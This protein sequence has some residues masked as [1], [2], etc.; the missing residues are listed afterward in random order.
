MLTNLAA[1]SATLLVLQNVVLANDLWKTRWMGKDGDAEFWGCTTGVQKTFKFNYLSPMEL[2]MMASSS[3]GSMGSMGSMGSSSTTYDSVCGYPPAIGSTLL[4]AQKLYNGSSKR[5]NTFFKSYEYHCKHES[6]VAYSASYYESQYANATEYQI[7]TDKIANISAPLYL[8]SLPNMTIPIL[9]SKAYNSRFTTIDNSNYFAIAIVL[10]F[11]LV[12]L[13][14]AVH[15]LAIR[16]GSIQKYS[17]PF[18]NRFRSYVIIPALFPHGKYMQAAGWEWCSTLL[19]NRVESIVALGLFV[20]QMV[21]WCVPYHG[22]QS[23]LPGGGSDG[24]GYLYASATKSWCRLVGYRTGIM[25]FGKIPLAIFFS[26]RNNFLTWLTGIKYSSLIQFHKMLSRYMFVD[27]LIHSIAFSIIH[28]AIFAS[29]LKTASFA[30]GFVATVLA[31]TMIIFSWHPFRKHTYEI[32]LYTHIVLAVGFLVTCWYHCKDDG[33]SEWIVAA[34]AYWAYDR[35]LRLYRM[36]TFGYKDAEISLV[37]G[38]TLKVVVKR[39]KVFVF[40]PGQYGFVYFSDS[41]LWFQSHPFSLTNHNGDI[42]MYIK[43][44]HGITD[45]IY[46]QL[47]ETKDGILR[48][49]VCIEGPYGKS[50][51][52][53]KYDNVVMF[54][55]GNGFPAIFGYAAKISGSSKTKNAKIIWIHRTL[56]DITLISREL[57][58]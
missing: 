24:G 42:L 34:C 13:I 16:T 7:P 29:M 23:S 2:E 33:W 6:T 14:A 10:Y 44:K 5:M 4:C 43:V 17:S 37:N 41:W 30:Y 11:A 15:N 36:A 8:P 9:K 40:K 19:P 58:S 53:F 57:I 35:L 51:P 21:F 12:L 20:L 50:A 45:K 31:A 22:A 52:V 3:S 18:I 54:T 56:E 38:D 25:S 28:K 1:V 39:P 49:K 47:L 48:K 27:A 46:K 55:A 26:G 32:F